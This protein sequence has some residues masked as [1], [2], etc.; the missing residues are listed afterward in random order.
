[1][2]LEREGLAQGADF[3]AFH[4]RSPSDLR[5]ADVA[6]RIIL[7]AAGAAAVPAERAGIGAEKVAFQHLALRDADRSAR[8]LGDV[9]SIRRAVDFAEEARLAVVL[10]GD[11][12]QARLVAVED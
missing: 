9:E 2:L 12:G 3:D 8:R 1:A 10:P 6:G 4:G 7:S 5:H 11:D